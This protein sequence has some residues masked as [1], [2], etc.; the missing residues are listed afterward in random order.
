MSIQKIA[1]EVGLSDPANGAL[2]GGVVGGGVVGMGLARDLFARAKRYE[3]TARSAAEALE[4]LEG[5]H[6]L[7]VLARHRGL[8]H[9]AG[10]ANDAKRLRRL[11]VAA[12]PMWMLAG[13]G[14]GL[15][16]RALRAKS[17]STAMARWGQRAL[18]KSQDP[19]AIVKG[20]ERRAG[21]S[22]AQKGMLRRAKQEA[23]PT[24]SNPSLARLQKATLNLSRFNNQWAGDLADSARQGMAGPRGPLPG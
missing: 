16:Y 13:A 19:R 22:D 21:L 3:G 6:P 14:A 2:L 12:V 1:E 10:L 18:S 9:G 8:A 11:G 24:S 23:R 20:M 15:G 17:S 7:E 4:L 5:S